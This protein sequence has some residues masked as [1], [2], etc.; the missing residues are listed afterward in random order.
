[1]QNNLNQIRKET[2]LT[3]VNVRGFPF[4]PKETK[5]SPGLRASGGV[6]WDLCLT[7]TRALA[8]EPFQKR[9]KLRFVFGSVNRKELG[10]P[11]HSGVIRASGQRNH[12]PY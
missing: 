11:H 3:L 12:G 8:V 7:G 9:K 6:N 5:E 10:L 4:P 1:L 2:F